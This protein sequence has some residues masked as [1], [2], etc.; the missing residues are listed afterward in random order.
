MFRPICLSLLIVVALATTAC[1]Q[2]S[3]RSVIHC[4]VSKTPFKLPY[5]QVLTDLNRLESLN[6]E[7][8]QVLYDADADREHEAKLR[9]ESLALLE[10]HFGKD[11][12][13]TQ[14]ER[15]QL[16]SA[17]RAIKLKDT[18]D[19]LAGRA[20]LAAG[21]EYQRRHHFDDAITEL[22]AALRLLVAT[23]DPHDAVAIDCKMNLASCLAFQKQQEASAEE[24]AEAIVLLKAVYGDRHPYVAIAI[25]N[26]GHLESN[27]KDFQAAMV[28]LRA[29]GRILTANQLQQSE[30]AIRF[31]SI[32]A[33]AFMALYRIGD[34]REAASGAIAMARIGE[35]T[36][37]QN[38]EYMF[39]C[40]S[41]L[42]RCYVAEERPQAAVSLLAPVVATLE[43]K[44]TSGV[45][46]VHLLTTY[47]QALK[48]CGYS[49]EEQEV[50]ERI[51]LLGRE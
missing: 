21:M 6:N 17:E 33:G 37:Q 30:D 39:A 15:Q 45:F 18:P 2:S 47:V 31:Q 19:F 36:S 9:R 23:T 34:A 13:W 46:H 22:K 49:E 44:S 7:A 29:A 38:A 10:K 50:A 35:V 16:R 28:H 26:L 25:G 24:Y 48:R 12:W 14:A 5:E 11:H 3:L 20:K 4:Q 43:Q 1:A 27:Q 40:Y 32:L 41:I 8:S 42:G 51:R